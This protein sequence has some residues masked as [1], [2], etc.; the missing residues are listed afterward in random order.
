MSNKTAR[1]NLRTSAQIKEMGEKLAKQVGKKSLNKL[2]EDLIFKAWL[3]PEIF[4]S[5]CPTCKEPM[6]DPSDITLNE[7]VSKLECSQGH[8]SYFDHELDQF[9]K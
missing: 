7:G 9:V 5:C 4:F 8:V 1:I 2:I 3:N 6:F